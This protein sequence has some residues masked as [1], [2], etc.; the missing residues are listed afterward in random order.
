MF[1]ACADA[2]GSRLHIAKGAQVQP[3]A[4][5][6]LQATGGASAS[7]AAAGAQQVKIDHLIQTFATFAT[8]WDAAF[9]SPSQPCSGL[10]SA[11]E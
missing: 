4:R 11:L 10:V 1:G 2:E 7:A 5:R 8:T 3:A 9:Q 6:L